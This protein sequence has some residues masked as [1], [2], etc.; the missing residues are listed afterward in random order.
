MNSQ[1]CG[2]VATGGRESKLMSPPLNM[3]PV[4]LVL[5]TGTTSQTELAARRARRTPQ[6]TAGLPALRW[7]RHHRI[8][9]IYGSRQLRDQHSSRLQLR[10]RVAVGR[11]GGELGCNA[12]PGDVR[13][14][15]YRHGTQPCGTV[16]GAVAAA[17]RDWHVDSIRNRRDGD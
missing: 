17:D 6:R 2:R 15:G 12:I 3:P 4:D 13:Q 16:Q 1:W 8:G 7:A 10:L 5:S 14:I 9:R 11:A